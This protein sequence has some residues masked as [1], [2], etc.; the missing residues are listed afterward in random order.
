MNINIKATN[1]TLTPS[2]KSFILEK[3]EVDVIHLTDSIVDAIEVPGASSTMS[4]SYQMYLTPELAQV[5]EHS[6]KVAKSMNDE[7]A[8]T[9]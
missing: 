2:I 8:S 4:Q 7:L 3:L 6:L 9:E 1:T 5:I